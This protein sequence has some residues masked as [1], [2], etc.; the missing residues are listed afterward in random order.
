[1]DSGKVGIVAARMSLPRL[2][3]GQASVSRVWRMRG[4]GTDERHCDK[5][6][7]AM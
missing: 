1:V 2:H 3:S 4:Y 7:G 5:V 6:L